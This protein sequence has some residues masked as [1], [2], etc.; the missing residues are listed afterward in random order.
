MKRKKTLIIGTFILT[1]TGLISRTIGFFYRIFLSRIFGEEGMGVYQL[2][3]PILSLSFAIT[4]AGMQ[5]AISKYVAETSFNENQNT[6]KRVLFT[7]SFLSLCLSFLCTYV[8]YHFSEVIATHLLLEERTASMIRILSFSIP[9]S[10]IHACVN[11]YFYGLKKTAIPASSQLLEQIC[12]VGCVYLIYLHAIKNQT[13]PTLNAAIWG[14]VAGE[15]FAVILCIL[16][17]LYHCK[18]NQKSLCQM[19]F[20][21]TFTYKKTAGLLILMA[22]PLSLNRVII[23]ILQSIEAV[24]IPNR[25]LLYGYDTKTALSVYGVLTGMALPLILFPGALTN[26][27]SVLLLPIISEAKVSNDKILIKKAIFK[28]IQYC[29]ILGFSC[30]FSFLILGKP[31]GKFLFHSNLAG[32]FIMTL[33][34]ICPFLYLNTTL[35]SIMH[36]LGK[37]SIV[38][39]IHTLSL[40]IRLCFVLISIPHLGI[41]GYLYGLLLSQLFVSICFLYFLIKKRR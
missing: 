16:S 11:G 7:G 24:Q 28:T 26:S 3:S 20:S 8:L 40:L 41:R 5:T 15:F 23:N 22:F 33:S 6:P 39:I 36:G 14:L 18:K 35:S 32:H 21:K 31:I 29:S 12:R 10:A 17:A 37:I 4:A 27:V 30:M 2:L 25:L 38:F 34:F 13:S 1:L 9:L 19:S